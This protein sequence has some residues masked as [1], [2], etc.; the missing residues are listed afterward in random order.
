MPSNH[1]STLIKRIKQIFKYRKIDIDEL[2]EDNRRMKEM[3]ERRS[4][5]EDLGALAASLEHD[6]KNPLGVLESDIGTM[7]SKFQSNPEVLSW[8]ARLEAQKRRIYAATG[9]IPIVR[10]DADFNEKFVSKVSIRDLINGCV[11]TV[12]NEVNTKDV[13]FLVLRQHK[14]S[15]NKEYFVPAYAPLLQQVF[16]NILKNSIEAIHESKRE[17]GVINVELKLDSESNHLLHIEIS[18]NGCGIPPENISKLTSLFTTK[19]DRRPNS[20]IG[21]YIANRIMQIHRGKLEIKSKPGE[22]TVALLTLPR[23]H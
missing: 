20:G 21:L 5:L 12:K 17:R 3:L 9:I 19:G 14:A 23:H 10:V 22:G 7:K 1:L 11:K 16:I 4:A 6:I 2:I 13:S 18:D 8:L 15:S